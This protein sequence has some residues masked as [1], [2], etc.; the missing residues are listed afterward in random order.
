MKPM[1]EM[2]LYFEILKTKYS[3]V[4]LSLCWKHT[5][6]IVEGAHTIEQIMDKI[7]LLRNLE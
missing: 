4:L 7:S 2:D 3:S 1:S 6:K 5:V